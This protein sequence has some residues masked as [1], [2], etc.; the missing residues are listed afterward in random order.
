MAPESGCPG[1]ICSSRIPCGIS[2]QRAATPSPISR[3]LRIMRSVKGSQSPMPIWRKENRRLK[4]I[5]P[6]LKFMVLLCILPFMELGLVSP[7]LGERSQ[8]ESDHEGLAIPLH[9]APD[10][11]ADRRA[12]SAPAGSIQGRLCCRGRVACEDV[13]GIPGRE[14]SVRHPAPSMLH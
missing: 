8:Q 6:R 3:N 4:W 10:Y 2:I 1:T 14:L 12:S 9:L 5:A 13:P 7:K 11:K